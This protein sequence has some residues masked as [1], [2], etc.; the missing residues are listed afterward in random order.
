MNNKGIKKG[1]VIYDIK[2]RQKSDVNS[3]IDNIREA[4]NLSKYPWNLIPDDIILLCFLSPSGYDLLPPIIAKRLLTNYNL[5]NYEFFEFVGDRVLSI[6]AINILFDIMGNKELAD[7]FY[8]GKLGPLFSKITK[9]ATL[10]CIMQTTNLCSFIFIKEKITVKKCA[11]VLE[12][13]LGGLYYYKYIINKEPDAIKQ[14]TEWFS[15]TF[16]VPEVINNIIKNGDLL[17]EK[18]KQIKNNLS[19]I[20]SNNIDENKNASSII[21]PS[22]NN[23]QVNVPVSPIKNQIVQEIPQSTPYSPSLYMERSG[24]F[25]QSEYI[26]N[27]KLVRMEDCNYPYNNKQ[28][29]SVFMLDSDLERLELFLKLKK[30]LSSIK[31]FDYNEGTL[32]V[33]YLGNSSANFLS[34]VCAWSENDDDSVK[35]LLLNTI[36][37]FN[38]SIIKPTGLLSSQ[39]KIYPYD[40]NCNY[41]YDRKNRRLELII[42]QPSY[43]ASARDKKFYNLKNKNGITFDA[44]YLLVGTQYDFRT[45]G[46][47]YQQITK[48]TF[49]PIYCSYLNGYNSIRS[50]IIDGA[51]KYMEQTYN[52]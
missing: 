33:L 34:Y 50:D 12:A 13:L 38:L 23:G 43:T 11:D 3:V 5:K 18:N 29:S 48:D 36:E 21:Y 24:F 44:R 41:V 40:A 47:L 6:V 25:D 9:N 32:S 10:N 52:Y 49:I 35:N 14:I 51:I 22:N 16:N 20:K 45:I 8:Q 46:V 26:K 28:K 17:C 39:Y 15:E 37:H 30:L 2:F 42:N 31:L 19:S 7:N 27:I 4:F 1:D